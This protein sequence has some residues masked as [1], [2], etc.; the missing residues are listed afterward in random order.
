MDSEEILFIFFVFL[1]LLMGIALGGSF[2]EWSEAKK[3]LD[4]CISPQYVSRDGEWYR[5]KC[6]NGLVIETTLAPAEFEKESP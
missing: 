5:Y 3:H 1:A 2:A 4:R 6:E